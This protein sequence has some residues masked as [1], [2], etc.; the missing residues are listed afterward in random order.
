MSFAKFASFVTLAALAAPALAHIE[1]KNP[2]PLRSSFNPQY[3][4]GPIQDTYTNPLNKDGSDFPCK[5][6]HTDVPSMSHAVATINAGSNF[7]VDLAGSA[8]RAYSSHIHRST[9]QRVSL[10]SRRWFLPVQCFVRRC[11]DLRR[12]SQHRW[13]LPHRRRQL[14]SSRPG[15]PSQRQG[16]HLCMDLVS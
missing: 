13:Q 15:R 3:K 8:V 5:G 1:M 6:F 14:P 12:D 9:T 4:D 10:G 7:T 16:H 11:K 2:P